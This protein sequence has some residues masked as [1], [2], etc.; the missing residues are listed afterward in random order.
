MKHGKN[1]LIVLL[2][3]AVAG[4]LFSNSK[5]RGSGVSAPET[6]A[7]EDTLKMGRRYDSLGFAIF[8]LKNELHSRTL[9]VVLRESI[10]PK[11]VPGQPAGV[12]QEPMVPNLPSPT[13][14]QVAAAGSQLPASI[15]SRINITFVQA[16]IR[17]SGMESW[18]SANGFQ[19]HPPAS[20][21]EGATN[22]LTFGDSVPRAAVRLISLE[23]FRR[24]RALRRIRSTDAE[25]MAST[26]S[27][28]SVPHLETATSLSVEQIQR[29]T[30][31]P[32]QPPQP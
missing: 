29:L 24:G 8:D 2:I 28:V 16:D 6:K 5:L 17:Q 14:A 23:L 27:L 11:P 18:L 9:G 30:A 26:V 15:R 3:A 21:G 7:V 13:E 31:D 19:I 25:G 4:L 20:V 32:G 12:L 10:R 1:I 22:A